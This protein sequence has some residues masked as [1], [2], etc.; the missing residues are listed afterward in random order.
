MP[1][2][3][4]VGTEVDG[5]DFLYRAITTADWWVEDENRPSTAVFNAREFCADV[6][7]LAGDHQ[8]TLSR[9]KPGCGIVRFNAGVAR[10]LGFCARK[11]VDPDFPDNAAH[12][13][14]TCDLGNKDRRRAAKKLI[15]H[16]DTLV[17]VQPDLA[18]LA[19]EQAD[20]A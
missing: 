15:H 18:L 12:A 20:D 17:L 10:A 8:A 2:T 14:V 7:S 6:E 3:N 11:A 1:G 4:P 13:D 5:A 19:I 9:H 16:P